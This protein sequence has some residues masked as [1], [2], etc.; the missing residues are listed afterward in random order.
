MRH[1][2]AASAALFLLAACTGDPAT[3]NAALGAAGGALVGQFL[4]GDTR[5]TVAGA[6]VGAIAGG[7]AG[8]SMQT[9]QAPRHADVPTRQVFLPDGSSYHEVDDD[10]IVCRAEGW[11]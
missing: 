8:Q 9:T 1:V 2:I 4:G 7:I 10:M 5:S 11:C 3:D 6:A